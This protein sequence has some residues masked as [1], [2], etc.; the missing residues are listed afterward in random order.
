MAKIKEFAK[1]VPLLPI[2][3]R[4]VRNAYTNFRQKLIN[5]EQVFTDIYNNNGWGGQV[6]VSGPGS[7][8]HQ[9]R[10]I[11]RELPILFKDLSIKTMLDIPCGD[12]N[13]MN[14]VNLDGTD[15]I[16]ADIVNE[17][18]KKN[19]EQFKKNDVRFLKLNLL[20]DELPRVDLIFCRDCLVHFPVKDIF[21][22]LGN[23]YTSRSEYL[24]TTTFT[25]RTEN[26]DIETGQ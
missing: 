13:W 15:Y 16:G 7:D 10:I 3:Y 14:N 4:R 19:I 2:V 9:S 11:V 22:A 25:E 24:L 1:K 6:S 8:P 20:T 21:N 18:I 17:L 12:F 5:T 26:Q 23:I